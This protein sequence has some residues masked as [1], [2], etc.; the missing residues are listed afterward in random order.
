MTTK[1]VH[2]LTIIS[3]FVIVF[4]ITRLNSVSWLNIAFALYVKFLCDFGYQ[5]ELGAYKWTWNCSKFVK[6]GWG[7]C[8][9]CNEKVMRQYWRGVGVCSYI[10]AV[11]WRRVYGAHG[12]MHCHLS[13]HPWV[14]IPNQINFV[15]HRLNSGNVA[16][17]WFQPESVFKFNHQRYTEESLVLCLHPIQREL[18]PLHRRKISNDGSR[19]ITPSKVNC[20]W[21]YSRKRLG[22]RA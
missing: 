21:R 20:G 9:G 5:H 22:L 14:A 7:L 10:L 8:F 16:G 1:K 18:W 3:L 17:F 13:T 19:W 11:E 4:R 6:N 12:L 15:P 2:F